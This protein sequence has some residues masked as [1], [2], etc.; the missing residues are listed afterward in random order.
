MKKRSAAARLAGDSEAD[1]IEN[2]LPS[3]PRR[4]GFAHEE[5]VAKPPQREQTGWLNKP[6]RPLRQRWLRVF[7]LDVASIRRRL[8]EELDALE[9]RFSK[10]HDQAVDARKAL[11]RRIELLEERVR[12]AR[13]E[14]TAP[15]EN[16]AQ[17]PEEPQ[18]DSQPIPQFTTIAEPLP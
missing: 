7:I 4:G 18:I 17:E 16:F 6:P 3:F 2:E 15:T 1:L 13:V 5:N 10:A 9:L 14:S 12:D 8:R 11:E